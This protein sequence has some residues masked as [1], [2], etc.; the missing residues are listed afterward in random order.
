MTP[1]RYLLKV[2][3][4]HTIFSVQFYGPK[5]LLLATATLFVSPTD[6]E[7]FFCF[8]QLLLMFGTK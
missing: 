4:Y 6:L 8:Y 5:A 7:Q 3:S 1:H 2:I